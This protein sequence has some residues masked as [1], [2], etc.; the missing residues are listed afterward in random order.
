M[1]I[2]RMIIEPVIATKLISLFRSTAAILD[3]AKTVIYFNYKLHYL[4]TFYSKYSSVWLS[5]FSKEDF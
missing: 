3:V 2:N 1:A 5:S 4:M